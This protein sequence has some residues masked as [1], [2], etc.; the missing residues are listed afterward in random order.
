MTQKFKGDTTE[1]LIEAAGSRAFDLTDSALDDFYDS[2]YVTND[3]LLM[4]YDAGRMPFSDRVPRE[5]F[6]AF[7]T[8]ALPMAQVTGTFESYIFT[9]KSIFGQESEIL[10]NVPA[11]G[12]LD[13]IVNAQAS[14]VFDFTGREF[15]DGQFA[16]F[17]IE[18]KD[19]FTL[20]FQGIAGVDSA[21]ELK[22]LLSELI[23]AGLYV[24]VTLEVFT[25][26]M[27]VAKDNLGAFD[28]VVD[29]ANNQIVFFEI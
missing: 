23:P 22:Q 13:L 18:T 10:F 27:F 29:S 5:S 1:L 2:A 24:T 28:S 17:Q 19:G 25:V 11:P 3:F 21:P 9:I 7:I 4:L 14:L 20:Q 26:S 15:V 8:Q 6:V 12:K 16:F